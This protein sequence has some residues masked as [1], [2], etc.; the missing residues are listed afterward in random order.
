QR[1]LFFNGARAC[2]GRRPRIPFLRLQRRRAAARGIPMTTQGGLPMTES[3]T[4]RGPFRWRWALPLVPI[5]A[6]MFC[7]S[8]LVYYH[9]AMGGTGA[10]WGFLQGVVVF[11]YRWLGFVPTFMFWLLLFIWCSIWFVVGRW[12]NVRARLLWMVAFTLCTAILVNLGTPADAPPHAGLVGTFIASRLTSV[13]GHALGA[14]L[15][16]AASLASLLLATDFLFYRYFEALARGRTEETG[17]EPEATD[18]FREL[19]FA[20]VYAGEPLPVR[21]TATERAGDVPDAS[22][23]GVVSVEAPVAGFATDVEPDI[24]VRPRRRMRERLARE[25]AEAEAVQRTA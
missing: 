17:V 21:T 5:A 16:V 22:S 6:S 2:G 12:E 24:I 3:L 25:Q 9:T 8:A 11:C 4:D 7:L 19:A 10:A 23:E 1:R 15:A 13:V 14:L 20:G 18:A